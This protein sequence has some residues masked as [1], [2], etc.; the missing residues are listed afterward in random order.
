MEDS[1]FYITYVG[2]I[3]SKSAIQKMAKIAMETRAL[4]ILDIKELRNPKAAVEY[5]KRNGLTGITPSLG[6]VVIP[7]TYGFK[8]GVSDVK[9]FESMDGKLK[10]E[11]QKMAVPMA[12]AFIGR[13]MGENPG[14]AITGLEAEAIGG[15]DGVKMQYDKE[16]DNSE[17]L[18]DS[19]LVMVL[20]LSLI[21][22]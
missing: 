22:I 12:C 21:H 20:N 1:P 11:H 8:Q 13:M 17:Q 4:A 14:N 10:A 5:A 15:I 3:G 6:H 7:A 19:G 18:S 16:R 2:N 9:Y